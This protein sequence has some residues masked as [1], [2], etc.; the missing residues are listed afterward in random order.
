MPERI[1]YTAVT[2]DHITPINCPHCRGPA[3]LTRRSPAVTA[4][5]NGEIRTFDCL[6]CQQQTE[7]FVRD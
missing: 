6:A 2:P 3:R 7:M 1:E 4:D 5:G